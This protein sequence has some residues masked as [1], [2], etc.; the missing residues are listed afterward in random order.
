MKHHPASFRDP[1]GFIF[2][3]DGSLYRQVNSCFG[4]SFDQFLRC[5]LY[6]KLVDRGYLVAH[7]DVT[8][9][10]VPRQDGC[11]RVLK[12][13]FLPYI[14]YPY[15]WSFSQ[16]KDAAMLTLR[17]QTLALAHGFTLKDASAYNIQFLDGKPVLIDTLSLEPHTEGAPW[18]AYR[19]FCQHFLA[20]LALMALVDVD[21]GM[22]TLH[23]I[24]GVPLALA[25]KLL[26]AKTRF[27]VGLQA[28]IHVHARLQSRHAGD[29]A[30]DK[31]GSAQSTLTRKG[32]QAIVESL[33][34]CVKK[35]EW[36]MPPT[37]WGDYY[38]NTNYSEDSASRK[39][40][41]VEEFLGAVEGPVRVIQ[42]L[43]ANTGEFSR[44]AAKYAPL[45]VSQDIDP[46]AVEQNYAR[47]KTSGP[48]N[49]LPLRQDLFAPAPA[50]GWAN[51]EREAFISRASCDV[52]LALALIHHLAISNNVPLEDVA[53]LFA[54]L[55]AWAIVEFVPKSDSQVSRLL[56]TR[57]DVFPNYTEAGF[58]AAF[59][60]FFQ[61]ADK[62]PIPDSDRTLYLLRR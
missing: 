26:P 61:I 1:S 11:H 10:D 4:E 43:G 6:S 39:R 27:N 42:D 5:G 56:A 19:Q 58:E 62:R 40:A 21:L 60:V 35:L 16:L 33:A 9:T 20:P 50:I 54:E 18:V 55:A 38:D 31:A 14:S 25:S 44:I 17:I 28:H 32:I 2:K 57:E 15:E 48:T 47:V 29:S 59:G 41:L 34:S 51:R 13:T 7:E 45:V 53:Q 12:P 8:D 22:L 24:D 49:V 23:H 52:V 30:G 37:E 36:R 46:A 3:H